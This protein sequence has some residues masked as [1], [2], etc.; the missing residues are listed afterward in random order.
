MTYDDIEQWAAEVIEG[1]RIFNAGFRMLPDD[2][3]DWE[4]VK[5]VPIETSREG[6]ELV[7][8]WQRGGG[9]ELLRIQV[10]ELADW[11][12]ALE[13]LREDLQMSMRSDIPRATGALG[14][15]GDIAFGARTP[16]TD[17]PAAVTFVR[18]NVFVSVRSVGD[19]VADASPAA[20]WLDEALSRPP[21]PKDPAGKAIRTRWIETKPRRAGMEEIIVGRV[22]E[23]T[24]EGWLK[25]LATDGE[26]RRR[27]DSLIYVSGSAKPSRVELFVRPGV[28][29]RGK[30]RSD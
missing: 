10:A 5:S 21:R 6:S 17:I 19:R 7:H 1:R 24:A 25:V 23:A 15:L 27:G 4:F 3:Q 9:R 14:K 28:P 8:M 26:L 2:L 16:E 29:A 18:G 12:Q 20:S 13:R 30:A 11:S 22:A